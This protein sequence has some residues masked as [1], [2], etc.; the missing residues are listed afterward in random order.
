MEKTVNLKLPGVMELGKMELQL[1]NG[2]WGFL[3][4]IWI[5]KI[6]D[7]VDDFMDGVWDGFSD[8]NYKPE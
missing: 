6:K 5:P 7:A 4:P 8:N 3:G 1:T 2:G